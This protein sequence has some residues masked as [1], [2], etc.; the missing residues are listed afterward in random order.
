L[1]VACGYED[2]GEGVESSHLGVGSKGQ[3]GGEVDDAPSFGF[4][5]RHNHHNRSLGPKGHGKFDGVVEFRGVKHFEAII[6]IACSYQ[7]DRH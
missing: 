7:R 1:A 4:V 6:G 5:E 2:A 3:A